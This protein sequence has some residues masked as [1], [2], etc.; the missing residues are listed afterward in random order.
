MWQSDNRPQTLRIID[1]LV[2][3]ILL[4][5]KWSQWWSIALM[6]TS[7]A[8]YNCRVVLLL[9]NI[10][11]LGIRLKVTWGF[12]CSSCLFVIALFIWPLRRW[13]VPACSWRCKLTLNETTY[14]KYGAMSPLLLL[15]PIYS[16]ELI[17]ESLSQKRST[18]SCW[19][20]SVDDLFG[21]LTNFESLQY[22]KFPIIRYLPAYA[23]VSRSF[24]FQGSD[25]MALHWKL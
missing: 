7:C 13:C 2:I 17:V 10:C 22:A 18:R 14:S 1:L 16:N 9:S 4:L 23:L 8:R 6:S 5:N 12:P 15:L 25:V 20:R 11:I 24:T 21:K 19:G 3:S